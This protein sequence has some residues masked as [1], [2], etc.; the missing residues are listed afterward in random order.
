MSFYDE[1]KQQ[2][3]G[4]SARPTFAPELY[5]N[6]AIEAIKFACQVGYKNKQ[7]IKGYLYKSRDQE[8]EKFSCHLVSELPK[9][10]IKS[11]YG[12]EFYYPYNPNAYWDGPFFDID[13]RTISM[14]KSE[15]QELGL[16]R[17]SIRFDRIE[18]EKGTTGFMHK[19]AYKKTG[20]YGYV[21]FVEVNW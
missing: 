15:F 18:I 19:I 4:H 13:D 21:I 2:E 16:P 14:I 8:L 7:A 12:G 1:L 11:E 20:I 6:S 5:V 9:K 17:S 10:T 3:A